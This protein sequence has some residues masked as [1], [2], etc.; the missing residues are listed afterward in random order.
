MHPSLFQEFHWSL[1]PCSG[2]IL[3]TDEHTYM[4][5]RGCLPSVAAGD[6]KHKLTR[7]PMMNWI[8]H[9]SWSLSSAC[10]TPEKMLCRSF[11][12]IYPASHLWEE[13]LTLVPS[14]WAWWSETGRL[15]LHLF[16]TVHTLQLS[17]FT[18]SSKTWIWDIAGGGDNEA[19]WGTKLR[20]G[21]IQMKRRLVALLHITSKLWK[22]CLEWEQNKIWVPLIYTN[23]SCSLCFSRH[24]AWSQHVMSHPEWS[25]FLIFKQACLT[26]MHVN[27]QI[28]YLLLSSLLLFKHQLRLHFKGLRCARLSSF[29]IRSKEE[30]G[31]NFT[32]IFRL[33]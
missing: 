1:S 4:H 5:F 9:G 21:N 10:Q 13:K 6:N 33:N 8:H 15:L 26:I 16:I 25:S 27:E 19:A 23:I 24:L 29:S 30:W 14:H 11:W 17:D 20:N 18:L 3:L 31:N 2:V 22:L 12:L 32:F 28:H 7:V